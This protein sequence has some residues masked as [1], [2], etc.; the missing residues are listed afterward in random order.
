MTMSW[1]FCCL[2]G[3][4][5]SGSVDSSFQPGGG[6]QSGLDSEALSI[7]MQ[8]DGKV[9]V[10][11]AFTKV[12]RTQR[13]GI[14]RLNAD[15]SHDE[16]FHPG[17][18]ANGLVESVVLM[19]DGS[20]VVAGRFTM[21][22][23]QERRY[24]ARL[25][26]NGQLDPD[27]RP[28]LNDIAVTLAYGGQNRVLVGGAF[29]SIDGR[30]CRH[31]ARIRPDGTVDADFSSG[32]DRPVHTI[33]RQG[34]GRIL[35]GGQFTTVHGIPRVRVARLMADGEV[36]HTFDV[37]SGPSHA[38]VTSSVQADGRVLI[39][40]MFTT[41]ADT[42]RTFLA[43]LNLDGTVDEAF[44]PGIALAWGGV[45][46]V[47]ADPAGGVIVGGEFEKVDGLPR[48]G[49]ARLL[50][51][52]SLDTGFNPGSGLANS[53][54]WSPLAR[55][56]QVQADGKV[57]VGGRFTSVDGTK[58]NRVARLRGV[59]GGSV[60][61]EA[62]QFT[63]SNGAATVRLRR[64][65]ALEGVVTVNLEVF[66]AVGWSGEVPWLERTVTFSA[67]ESEQQV[68][69]EAPA[70]MEGSAEV[71]LALTNPVGG[72]QLGGERRAT[73]FFDGTAPPVRLELISIE[74]IDPHRLRLVLSAPSGTLCIL[75]Q[76]DR[77][78]GGAWSSVATNSAEGGFCVYEVD[79]GG[80]TGS[81]FFRAVT[82]P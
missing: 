5:Q 25:D 56:V 81:G 70:R 12:G 2:E 14:A 57:L 30:S 64:G 74:R 13:N 9:V 37:G 7:A 28:V 76:A 82:A 35:I 66:E 67:G 4:S 29:T 8:A 33:S 36:D 62:S 59:A 40:S 6:N 41:V 79:G 77:V 58:L 47:Q 65:G 22:A 26:Q 73:I 23:G 21:F 80:G 15:G 1:A 19:P 50:E 71:L 11:G 18:G 45:L 10:A 27:F 69:Y 20:L 61:F 17:T 39:G 68:T 34:D 51:D 42:T 60:E 44:R 72:I 24:L 53:D 46:A 52:G 38:V 49:I 16:G 54:G 32:P 55:T 63:A 31:I 48:R 78:E 75:Q 43:R 3:L